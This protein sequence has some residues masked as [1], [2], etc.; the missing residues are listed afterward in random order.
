MIVQN[1]AECQHHVADRTTECSL[2]CL[3]NK[4][5]LLLTV[6][7]RAFL[8]C[9]SVSENAAAQLKHQWAGV[10][11]AH[12]MSSAKYKSMFGDLHVWLIC[13]YNYTRGASIAF[14]E[15]CRSIHHQ[16]AESINVSLHNAVDES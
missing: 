7:V 9:Y 16:K 2:A 4:C 11:G 6:W 13:T 14:L 3:E 1:N 12:L 8:I 10:T 5:K 15:C